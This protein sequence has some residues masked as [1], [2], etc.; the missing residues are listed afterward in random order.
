MMSLPFEDRRKLSFVAY[1]TQKAETVSNTPWN[2]G[3]TPMFDEKAATAAM[4]RYGMSVILDTIKKLNP[5][6]IPVICGDQ[7]LFA[8]IKQTQWQFP[9]TFRE[10]EIVVTLG[11]LHLDMALWMAI[12]KLLSN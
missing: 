9:E 3:L 1:H 11:G 12:G 10:V 2:I 6:E 7:P 8:L 4:M 5:D